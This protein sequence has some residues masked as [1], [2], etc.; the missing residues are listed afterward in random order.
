MNGGQGPLSP[1]ALAELDRARMYYGGS[2]VS[3][4]ASAPPPPGAIGPTAPLNAASIPA[5][6]PADYFGPGPAKVTVG[7]PPLPPAPGDASGL[8]ANV[9]GGLETAFG[10]PPPK[11]SAS[12]P[13]YTGGPILG[14]APG[15]A[16]AARA[17]GVPAAMKAD[18]AAEKTKPTAAEDAAYAAA[19]S[20]FGSGSA[21]PSA[22]GGGAA[23]PRGPS[24]YEKGVKGLRGTYDEDKGSTQRGADAEKDR[25]A[26]IAAGA[27]EIAQ[28]KIDDQQ[29]QAME[30]ANARQ[31]FDDY[32]AETQRQIDDVRSKR[33]EPNRAYNDTGSAV[34][35]VI[36]GALGGL[37]QGLNKM[38]TNPFIEQMNKTI[39]RDIA[40]Q[41]SDLRTQK[42]GIGE[43][44]GLLNEMR[45]TYKDEALAKLQARN[46]YYEGAKEALAAK[47]SEYDSPAIQSRADLAITALSREQT[48]LDINE[49][50]RK[51]AAAQAAGAAAEAMRQRDFDNRIKLHREG[52]EDRKLDI[53]EGKAGMDAGKDDVGRFVSTGNKEGAPTGY[54]ASDKE[55]AK[56]N[57]TS[58][59]AAERLIAQIDRVQEI[60][61]E[62]GT[63][64][65]IASEAVHGLYDTKAANELAV[66]ESNMTT[67][68]AVAAHLGAL[69]DSDRGLMTAKFRNLNSPGSGADERLNALRAALKRGLEVDA[70]QSGGATATKVVGRNGRERVQVNGGSTAP[71]NERT[72]KREAP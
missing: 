10:A 60:R 58:R 48:K 40:A 61:N 44:K 70:Q 52:I 41:E 16:T 49:A 63:G 65:R 23:G 39:D 71:V 45:A 68:Q 54:L 46:L 22:G 21:K 59:K 32:S 27:Q 9:Q 55:E 37:Y 43:R 20:H 36:G 64:G 17:A 42:E 8:P 28:Q 3:S 11:A 7:G 15:S 38:A 50:I 4:P 47:A 12:L 67:D 18:A 24:D 62:Q 29:A 69:S 25:A 30:A 66:L 33:I 2:D 26:L 72:V 31:H 51:A 56:E 14:I 35:A 57:R 6:N 5:F 19:L 53:E 34:L 13:D 1:E